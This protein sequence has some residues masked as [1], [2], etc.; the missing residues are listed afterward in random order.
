MLE[1]LR[2]SGDRMGPFAQRHGL[3]EE[4][5]RRWVRRLEG[6]RP[7]TAPPAP[8]P[9][10]APVRLVGPRGEAPGLEVAV[11]GAVVRVPRGFDAALL[12]E[13][14]AVLGGAPC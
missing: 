10:F 12:R 8:P 9:G 1:A 7:A 11:G 4:R 13:V 5:V 6:P 3:R 2:A 14:V